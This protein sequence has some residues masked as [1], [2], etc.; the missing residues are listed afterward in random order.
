MIALTAFK[1]AKPECFPDNA[2]KFAE[3]FNKILVNNKEKV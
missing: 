3:E 1:L 2:S